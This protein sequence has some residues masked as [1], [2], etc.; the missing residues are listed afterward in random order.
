[1]LQVQFF[2]WLII[3]LLNFFLGGEGAGALFSFIFY[4]VNYRF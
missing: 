4:L 1:M 2:F 3:D